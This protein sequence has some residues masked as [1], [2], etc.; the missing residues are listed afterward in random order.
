MS[1]MNLEDE[2]NDLFSVHSLVRD[3]TYEGKP[4]EEVKVSWF[5]AER[6]TP[7]V[8]FASAIEDYGQ[9]G[10]KDRAFPEE[11]V[12]EQFSKEEAEA[13]KKHLDRR[14][15]VS[16]RIEAVELPVAA[17]A[18]GCRHLPRGGGNDFLLLHKEKSYPLPFKVE[19]YFSIRFA[20]P[21]VSGDDGATVIQKRP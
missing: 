1:F 11:F 7:L 16:T 9:L 12:N 21:K 18:S 19:G 10:E 14:P 17:N 13:L 5:V 8:P 2:M 4:Y 15:T 20:E 3:F 6:Q